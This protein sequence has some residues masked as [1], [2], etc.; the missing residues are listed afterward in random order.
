MSRGDGEAKLRA[1]FWGGEDFCF[2][3]ER[4][5][6]SF[7]VFSACSTVSSGLNELKALPRLD[8]DATRL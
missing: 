2:C 4:F 6:K 3:N 7:L 8:L 1:V 5:P